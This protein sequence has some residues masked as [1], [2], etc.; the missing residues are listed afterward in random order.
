MPSSPP[1]PERIIRIREL[2]DLIGLSRSTIYGFLS[3][4]SPHH[5]PDFPKPIR[6]GSS[7]R[8][9]IGW[10]FHEVQRW[11]ETRRRSR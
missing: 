7:M 5:S 4:S 3:P 2:I 10:R 8:G 11:I 6:L 1:P 9:A